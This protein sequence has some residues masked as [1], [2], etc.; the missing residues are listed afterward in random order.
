MVDL[1]DVYIKPVASRTWKFSGQTTLKIIL[2]FTVGGKVSEL[3]VWFLEI[4][5]PFYWTSWGILINKIIQLISRTEANFFQRYFKDF[6]GSKERTRNW[7]KIHWTVNS[8]VKNKFNWE[9]LSPLVLFSKRKEEKLW[10]LLVLVHWE[11]SEEKKSRR[12]NYFLSGIKLIS[13]YS[14]HL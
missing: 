11:N 14:T 12:E 9:I 1:I 5:F 3:K 6:S 2:P 4:L 13:F 8:S 7:F 10:S